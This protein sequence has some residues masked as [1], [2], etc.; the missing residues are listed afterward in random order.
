MRIFFSLLPQDT[1]TAEDVM[2]EM[3]NFFNT[4][5]IRWENACVVCTDEA[6]AT[7]GSKSG[8]RAKVKELAQGKLTH[9]IFHP[10]PYHAR[11]SLS[12]KKVLKLVIELANFMKAGNLVCRLFKERCKD[13]N[14]GHE[15]LLFHTAVRWRCKRNILRRIISWM[16]RENVTK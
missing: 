5:G 4:E 2:E 10:M 6:P 3:V 7:F 14:A 16:F 9:C 13:M 1:S 11:Y 12:L 8:F 15:M